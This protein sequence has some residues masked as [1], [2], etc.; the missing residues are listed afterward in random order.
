[1]DG[2]GAEVKRRV[3]IATLAATAACIV[4]AVPARAQGTQPLAQGPVKALPPGGSFLSI[5][6]LPQPP[7]ANFGPHG[8]VPGFVYA[9]SGKVT[10][11]GDGSTFTLKEGEGHFTP[12][13]AVHTH[14]NSHNRL[15]AGAL[16]VGLVVA[17]LILLGA[18][19]FPVSR[20]ALV[21]A[22]LVAII[23][24]GALALWNP[25]ANEWFFF[26]IRPEGTRG[27]AMPLP[28][29][30]RTYES[31]AFASVP[32][33]PYVESLVATTVDPRG[34]V[35]VSTAPGP[36]VFLVLDGRAE[37]TA[38]DGPPLRLGHHQAT[39][40]QA[41]ESVGVVNPSGASLR[42]L[43]FALTPERS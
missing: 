41:G 14:K 11:A 37:I 12:A 8:H 21:P 16:A 17:V 4:M 15:A 42:L 34:R 6:S 25:W 28:G 36:I 7:G 43:R 3:L 32:P 19:R 30:S 18:A 1:L 26:G 39:L 40:V 29:A 31:P 24:G 33:G 23:A 5:V 2:P 35:P 27:A 13:L 20:A 9:V 22:L 10:I 38:G